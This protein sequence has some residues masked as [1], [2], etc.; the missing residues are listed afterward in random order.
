MGHDEDMLTLL[1]RPTAWVPIALSF[2]ILVMFWIYLSGVLPPEPT[3]DEGTAAHL[4]QLWLVLEIVLIGFFAV[5]WLA[6]DL[7]NAS[8]V[9]LLQL[10]GV[11]A[12]CFPV[13]YFHL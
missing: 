1:K 6:R 3:G 4:F 12:G 7:K 5:I 8:L 11:F 2:A 9:L 13:W 10:C